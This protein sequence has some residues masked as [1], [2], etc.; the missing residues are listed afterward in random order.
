M[1]ENTIEKSSV[2]E[3]LQQVMHPEIEGRNLVEL[4]MIPGVRVEERRVVVT[5]ALPFAA[6]PIREQL[7][8]LVQ[9]AVA[10]LVGSLEVDVEITEMG[11]KERETFLAHAKEAQVTCGPGTEIRKVVAVMSGKGGV[12]KSSVAAL[13]ASALRQR[14]FKVGILDAD[15]TGPSIPRMFG[16][17]QAPV[18]GENKLM[19]VESRTGIKLIS[20]NLLLQK[21]DQPVIWRGPIISKVIE[22]FWRDFDWGSLDYLVVDLPPGTSD[23]ALTVTQSLPL[24]GVV[25]VT[26]PQDLA[27]M[28]VRK[29]ASLVKQLGIP[30]IGLVGNM[31]HTVC[32]E[33]GTR[34]NLFGDN[35]AYDTARLTGARMLGEL[36]LDTRLAVLCDR[37]EIEDYRSKEFDAVVEKVISHVPEKSP[38]IR[39]RAQKQKAV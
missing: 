13:L 2:Y 17:T 28:I 3:R 11:V 31:T 25:M 30:L 18:A 39:E 15:I 32:P 23:A 16:V 10:G 5:L 34:I 19:P 4:G 24:N 29:A 12:G 36:P 38:E 20:I 21:E 35:R 9:Q 6:V 27:G 1:T 7:V 8:D 14:G 26:S 22:Q 37:G 33:C